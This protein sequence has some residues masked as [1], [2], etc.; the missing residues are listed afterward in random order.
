MT[1]PLTFAASERERAH[2]KVDLVKSAI[3]ASMCSDRLEDFII[4]S[5]KKTVAVHGTGQY[6]TVSCLDSDIFVNEKENENY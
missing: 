4:L 2:G 6:F 3:S 1:L 5:S